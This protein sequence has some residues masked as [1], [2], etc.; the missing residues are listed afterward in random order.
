MCPVPFVYAVACYHKQ[1]Y[2]CAQLWNTKNVFL[3]RYERLDCV[4]YEYM[5]YI[6]MIVRGELTVLFACKIC[7]VDC[8]SEVNMNDVGK[9]H[10]WNH[11]PLCLISLHIYLIKR[12]RN[13]SHG[14]KTPND[15]IREKFPPMHH[16]KAYRLLFNHITGQP[17]ICH[18]VYKML[19]YEHIRYKWYRSTW[20]SN[21]IVWSVD[22][23]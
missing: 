19:W 2:M 4:F 11:I 23:Q 7:I 12:H 1:N 6:G 16:C 14:A 18:L 10:L 21:F 13:N 3:V 9:F 22:S 8:G 17:K 15:V 20:W 5:Y